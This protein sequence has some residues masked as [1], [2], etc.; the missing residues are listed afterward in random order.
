MAI[1][2]SHMK[3][4]DK[5]IF[6]IGIGQDKSRAYKKSGRNRYWQNVVNKYGYIV[7]ILIENI[8]YEV[9]E[10]L[11]IFLIKYY[12]RKDLGIGNLVNLT[13]GAGTRGHKHTEETKEKLSKITKGR[14][15]WN[16][17]LSPSKDTKNKISKTLI[18]N[19][20]GLGFKHSEETKNKI[21]KANKNYV[22]DK[23]TIEKLRLGI[24]NS[25]K[26][27]GNFWPQEEIE[28]ILNNHNEYSDK[29]LHEKFFKHRTYNSV[30]SMRIKLKI[31][32]RI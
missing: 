31:K 14:P 21:A 18:G 28:I 5:E 29:E 17:G 6:Y 15:A 20:N 1:V 13:D 3:K 19:K 7:D 32:R 26:E 25:Y 4:C 10:Q 22:P 9:A 27:R 16:K 8:P 2:Y 12:G 24:I 30:R 23:E 11:E